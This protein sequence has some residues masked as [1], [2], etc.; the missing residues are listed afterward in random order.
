M[1]NWS[2]TVLDTLTITFAPTCSSSN[3][4]LEVG[5][6][7]I[8]Q[9]DHRVLTVHPVGDPASVITI[10]LPKEF[11]DLA[12]VSTFTN[13]VEPTSTN[14]PSDYYI[15]VREAAQPDV[16]GSVQWR[17]FIGVTGTTPDSFELLGTITDPSPTAPSAPWCWKAQS[18]MGPY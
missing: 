8:D 12:H 10:L 15:Q 17:G 3:T 7:H 16:Y 4:L 13:I 5:P 18:T 9:I 1:F 2:R 6:A 14:G 11:N